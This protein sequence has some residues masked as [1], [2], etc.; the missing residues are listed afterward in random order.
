MIVSQIPTSYLLF[1]HFLLLNRTIWP[2]F[3]FKF[4]CNE[5]S[6]PSPAFKSVSIHYQC[7]WITGCLGNKIKI[8][9]CWLFSKRTLSVCS[10]IFE[11]SII[12]LSVN[13]VLILQN[14]K[15]KLTWHQYLFLLNFF[16][17][18]KINIFSYS[19]WLQCD[20]RLSGYIGG[21]IVSWCNAWV[22]EIRI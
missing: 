11:I 8:L 16:S 21:T 2:R 19:T 3:W 17:K 20:I 14:V 15:L 6:D 9:S 7:R 18:L 5:L 22:E 1:A 10:A 13:S 4:E 12:N